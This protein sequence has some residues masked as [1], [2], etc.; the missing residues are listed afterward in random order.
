MLQCNKY[1]L[2]IDSFAWRVTLIT[3]V[4]RAHL[5]N[6]RDS[7]NYIATI[8]MCFT[9]TDDVLPELIISAWRRVFDGRAAYRG[10]HAV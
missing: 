8:E 4:T 5:N 7:C 3:I 10:L 1:I 9:I 6:V 2:L